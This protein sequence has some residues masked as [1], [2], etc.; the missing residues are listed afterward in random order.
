MTY[1]IRTPAD[2]AEWDQALAETSA[3]LD[4]LV[5]LAATHDHEDRTTG[6]VGLAADILLWSHTLRGG[7]RCLDC[8]AWAGLLAVSIE[9]MR[10][11]QKGGS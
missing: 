11:A 7:G 8:H 4:K 10:E 6:T 2:L 1:P 9:R 5:R 3:E